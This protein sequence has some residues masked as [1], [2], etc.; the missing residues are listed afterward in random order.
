MPLPKIHKQ[1]LGC[2]IQM[3]RTEPH[4]KWS[5]FYIY[6]FYCSVSKFQLRQRKC[7]CVCWEREQVRLAEPQ[8]YNSHLLANRKKSICPLWHI[9]CRHQMFQ[10]CSRYKLVVRFHEMYPKL[11]ALGSN[12]IYFESVSQQYNF[13]QRTYMP[14]SASS[15]LKYCVCNKE[16]RHMK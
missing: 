2:G 4:N 1:L 5:S 16:T 14:T 9:T 10:D 6:I 12:G 11:R 15:S 7:W 3:R 8:T 13:G